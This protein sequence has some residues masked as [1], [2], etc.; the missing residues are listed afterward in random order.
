MKLS[1]VI[2]STNVFAVS[3][4]EDNKIFYDFGTTRA[5]YGVY[6]HEEQVVG[7]DKIATTAL[8]KVQKFLAEHNQ[9]GWERRHIPHLGMIGKELAEGKWEY[10]GT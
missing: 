4:L 9:L 10:L 5:D 3:W 2:E 7:V 6:V 1:H 8:T